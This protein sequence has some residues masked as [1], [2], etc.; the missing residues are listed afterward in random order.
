MKE[1]P[2]VLLKSPLNYTGN[3]SR[4]LAEFPLGNDHRADFVVLAT[5]SGAFEIRLIEIK[6]PESKIFNKNGSLTPP[7]NKALE[8][9]NSWR[10][11]IEKN[12]Q[13][14]LRDIEKYGQKRD[15]IRPHSEPMTCTAGLRIH[16]ASIYLE[17]DIIIG[18]RKRLDATGLGRKAEFRKNNNVSIITSDRLL[19]GTQKIDEHP[20]VYL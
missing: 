14:F 12:R 18:R 5:Y 1:N 6:P 19:Q 13:E 17:F 3:P 4:V 16:D 10:T 9:V 20:E 2:F 8:Q 11:F 15:L 7:A